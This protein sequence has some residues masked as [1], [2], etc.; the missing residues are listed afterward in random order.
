[1]RFVFDI[2]VDLWF[3]RIFFYY[4]HHAC[5]FPVF[6]HTKLYHKFLSSSINDSLKFLEI[7]LSLHRIT[8]SSTSKLPKNGN[9]I[10]L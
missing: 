7:V 3:F 9:Q 4:C 8:Y 2:V 6:P 1:M 5:T 10:P